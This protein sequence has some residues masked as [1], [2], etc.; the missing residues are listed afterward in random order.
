M[1]PDANDVD[2]DLPPLPALFPVENVLSLP[3]PLPEPLPEPSSTDICHLHRCIGAVVDGDQTT[4]SI[5]APNAHIVHVHIEPSRIEPLIRIEGGFHVGRFAGVPAG[6]RYQFQIG[7]DDRLIP[8]PA[9]RQ[10]HQSV[11]GPSVVV[12]RRFD[13]TDANWRPVPMDDWIIYELHVGTWTPEGTFGS[14]IDRLDELVDLGVNAIE[15]MPVAD[16]A[17]RWNWGYDGVHLFAPNR[18][19]GTPEQLRSL[20]D[21][22]H[23][24]GLAVI[25][26]VVY[27]HLG[28]EGNYLSLAGP[29]LSQKHHTAWGNG[30][31]F[32]DP[33]HGDAC[34]RFF[35]ANALYWIE[36]F[37][38][39]ALRVDAIHCMR[40]DRRPHVAAELAAAMQR[41]AGQT[42]RA[43]LLI[44]ES[45]IYDPQ[46]TIDQDAGGVGFDAQWSDD[47]I[48]S[49]YACVRQDEQLSDRP[50][51][52][53]SDLKQVLDKG[54][55]YRGTFDQFR[56]RQSPVQPIETNRLVRCIQ[57]HDFI[58]NHPTGKR[59][60]AVTN[61]QTHAAM[62]ALMLLSP[63]IP[64]LFMGEEFACD[65]PFNFFVDF[66][67]D[68]LRDAVV[69]GRRREY[70]Q[71]DWSDGVL[72]TDQAAV[73]D[74]N[75]GP[76]KDQAM[77]RWYQSLIKIRRSLMVESSGLKVSRTLNES[78][79]ENEFGIEYRRNATEQIGI[80]I[81][82]EQFSPTAQPAPEILAGE[83]LGSERLG[84]EILLSSRDAFP[85]AAGNSWAIVYRVAQVV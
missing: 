45:N 11:H 23:Q 5:W 3:D 47:F 58:G 34:R 84:G 36:E 25:L 35:I 79:G 8:D 28:P 78:A 67:D 14:A 18:N 53:R 43:A 31:N 56:E 4:F 81:G 49:L 71:H 73:I 22:A 24:K 63:S 48:H 64:M 33:I 10:Q 40:D 20:I 66:G 50:Y 46:M 82:L 30:P 54:Y 60:T 59:I 37:H 74:S 85:F 27:N 17:G 19:Y 7:D 52:A 62:A 76:I 55:V 41:L 26:D 65:R 2:I 68:H 9:S 70:P 6:S 39:D 51:L 1:R 32:D 83:I 12:D 77:W 15:L 13:W 42:D 80:R 72:P 61:R 75:I 38:F 16:C 21:A 29:Y 57:N 69:E 44:A